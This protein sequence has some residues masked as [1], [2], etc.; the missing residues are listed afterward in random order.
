MIKRMMFVKG[1]FSL[2]KTAR[3]I[4]GKLLKHFYFVKTVKINGLNSN[5][6]CRKYILS[7]C[8]AT[9]FSLVAILIIRET[10]RGRWWGVSRFI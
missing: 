2:H 4:R 1:I 10:F 3:H 8:L 7:E 5:S 9:Y 6:S